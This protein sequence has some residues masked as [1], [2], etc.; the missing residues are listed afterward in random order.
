MS[1]ELPHCKTCN[2][3]T[4]KSNPCCRA[5][6]KWMIGP[7]SVWQV[8]YCFSESHYGPL[9]YL[10]ERIQRKSTYNL[11]GTCWTLGSTTGLLEKSIN[12]NKHWKGFTYYLLLF[13]YHK[14]V[15]CY[16]ITIGIVLIWTKKQNKSKAKQS[17]AKQYKTQNKTTYLTGPKAKTMFRVSGCPLCAVVVVHIYHHKV[18]LVIRLWDWTCGYKISLLTRID[19]GTL[20]VILHFS[21]NKNKKNTNFL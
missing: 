10:R 17:K 6:F 8:I 7:V 19:T 3:P 13:F 9:L 4:K 16:F 14:R 5:E 21:K 15:H 12:E 1:Q 11:T 18:G 2:I 20:K